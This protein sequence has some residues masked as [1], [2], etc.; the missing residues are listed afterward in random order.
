M[1]DKDSVT[2]VPLSS[3]PS[4]SNGKSDTLLFIIY[5]VLSPYGQFDSKP[6]LQ[7]NAPD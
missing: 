2:F 1:A 6:Q 7:R 4:I 5:H 3:L